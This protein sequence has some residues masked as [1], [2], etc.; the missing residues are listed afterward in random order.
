VTLEW[1][2]DRL[3]K[4][5]MH[6]APGDWRW[7]K[8]VAM[9][10]SGENPWAVGDSGLAVGL[11]QQHED[12]QDTYHPQDARPAKEVA[13]METDKRW[14]PAYQAA[15]FAT[16]WYHPHHIKLDERTRVISYHVGHISTLDEDGYYGAVMKEFA[17]IPEGV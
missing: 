13:W 6:K 2:F 14:H 12:F 9:H 5:Y 4:F 17:L 10:E 3:Y 1:R 8:A 15:C 7:V 11:L 16:F